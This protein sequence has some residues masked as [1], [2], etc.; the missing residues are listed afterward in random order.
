MYFYE[1]YGL[2]F[3]SNVEI[4]QL[5]VSDKQSHF[6]AEIIFGPIPKQIK[7]LIEDN[8]SFGARKNKFWFWNH[9]AIFYIAEGKEIIVEMLEGI[10]TSEAIPFILGY[11]ISI[12]FSQRNMLAIHCSSIHIDNKGI[13]LM[14]HSGAGKSS[15]TTRF[16]ESG[17]KFLTDDVAVLGINDDSIV[18]YPGFPQ[19]N[20][21]NDIVEQYG[22]DKK[23]L[24]SVDVDRDKYSIRRAEQFYTEAVCLSAMF[25][26]T[27]YM[28]EEVQ[29]EEVKGSEKLKLF[30]DNLFMKP[31]IDKHGLLPEHM[32]LCL[33]VVKTIPMY[34]L[35]RPIEVD[36]TVEQ[37]EAIKDSVMNRTIKSAD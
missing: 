20:L 11:C 1:L 21:C 23:S 24:T 37:M 26:L 2:V 27:P 3:R 5:L 12:L 31:I 17:Y 14:G 10:D 33:E 13:L 25:I 15:L 9:K 34:L 7:E 29:I 19:Q 28:G 16:L 8:D 35:K 18:V 6:E 4:K 36:S 22:Y 30:I 32:A